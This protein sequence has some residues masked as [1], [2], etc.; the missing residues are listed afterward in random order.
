MGPKISFITYWKIRYKRLFIM[1]FPICYER[2]ILHDRLFIRYW[3]ILHKISESLGEKI[4]QT[5]RMLPLE[6]TDSF[7]TQW[8]SWAS[9]LPMPRRQIRR[10]LPLEVADS[11]YA[12]V[13]KTHL[14]ANNAQREK[15][16][17]KF[18]LFSV[19]E[20]CWGNPKITRTKFHHEG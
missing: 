5:R 20:G 9:P 17:N 6:V 11:F 2:F 19:S 13:I 1:Y 7:F 10:M 15:M 18:W 3:K 12:T 16:I 4:G 8:L 14:V